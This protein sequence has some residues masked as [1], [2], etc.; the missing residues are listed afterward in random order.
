MIYRIYHWLR[1]GLAKLNVGFM[2]LLF[3]RDFEQDGLATSRI[4][5]FSGD[6][7]F[8]ES[9]SQTANEIGMDFQIDWRSHV[10]LW[11]FKSTNE[12]DGVAI[13]LGTGKAWMFTMALYHPRLT[14]LREAYLLDRFSSFSVDKI[15]GKPIPGTEN[16]VYTSDLEKLTARFSSEV[17]VKLIKGELPEALYSLPID[18]V[19]FVHVDLNASVPEVESLRFLWSKLVAGAIVL[20]DDYGSPEFLESNTAMRALSSEIGFEILGLPT[21]QGLIVKR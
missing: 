2:I 6:E 16:K 20:L 5:P 15:T 19:R 14:S 4:R 21:G 9:K 13:E 12:L 3:P 18:L 1:R 8:Q 7:D 11:A 17:G 10:F